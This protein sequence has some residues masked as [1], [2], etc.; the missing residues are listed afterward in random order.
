MSVYIEK[1]SAK[2]FSLTEILNYSLLIAVI[3]LLVF[4]AK[5]VQE[6]WKYALVK[7]VIFVVFSYSAFRV[8]A[9]VNQQIADI[10]GVSSHYFIYTLTNASYDLVIGFLHLEGLV[11][12]LS[13]VFILT[14]FV[15]FLF[16]AFKDGGHTKYLTINMIRFFVFTAFALTYSQNKSPSDTGENYEYSIAQSIW[17]YDMYGQDICEINLNSYQ[18][19]RFLT[20]NTA[21]LATKMSDTDFIFEK[22]PCAEI[23]S[24]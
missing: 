12:L 13:V 1:E 10:T 21:L 5:W 14:I 22:I 16:Q 17:D 3:G 23:K 11:A 20:K 2:A 6:I 4:I 18:R 24:E 8:L 19:I 15:V 9:F 7:M